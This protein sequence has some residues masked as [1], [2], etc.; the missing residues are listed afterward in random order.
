MQTYKEL[1]YAWL[2]NVVQD[3]YDDYYSIFLLH[4]FAQQFNNMYMYV[5]I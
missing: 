1:V 4:A 2:I 5:Y 3:S